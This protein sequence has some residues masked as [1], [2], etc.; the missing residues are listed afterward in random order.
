LDVPGGTFTPD[1]AASVAAAK[2]SNVVTWDLAAGRWIPTDF[3]SLSPDGSKYVE[4]NGSD[5]RII[6]ART[7]KV[8]HRIPTPTN[9]AN[10]L[11]GYT[12][13]AIYLDAIGKDPL[14]GLWRVDTKSWTLKKISSVAGLWDAAND[15]AAWGTD[16][17][18]TLRRLDFSTGRVTDIYKS[19]PGAYPGMQVAG[20]VASGVLVTYSDNLAGG[21]TWMGVFHQDGSMTPVVVPVALLRAGLGS[22]IQDGPAIVM[23]ATVSPD[24]PDPIGPVSNLVAYDDD[25]G[26]QLLTT[27]IPTDVSLLGRCVSS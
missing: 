19:D 8:L 22:P 10:D 24:L 7:G 12:D 3:R 6:D 15:S 21:R 1:P 25:H 11:V 18:S 9:A 14:P 27:N 5:I 26:L 4:P 20:F 23:T 13:S 17:G 2:A 16:G